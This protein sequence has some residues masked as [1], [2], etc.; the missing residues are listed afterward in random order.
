MALK[1]AAA[2]CHGLTTLVCGGDTRAED[3]AGRTAE[4]LDRQVRAAVS[5]G[6]RADSGRVVIDYGPV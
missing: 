4:A 3:D 2:L 1:V 5:M 6:F